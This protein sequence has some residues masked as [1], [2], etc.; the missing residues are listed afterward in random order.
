MGFVT[1]TLALST[2]FGQTSTHTHAHA[3]LYPC[4]FLKSGATHTHQ[5]PHP[6]THTGTQSEIFGL[7]VSKWQAAKKT[8]C[9][10]K[11]NQTDDLFSEGY[12]KCTIS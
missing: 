2:S 9:F 8:V 10:R 1:L 5:A 6:N 3:H 4:S 12:F 7:N 11:G